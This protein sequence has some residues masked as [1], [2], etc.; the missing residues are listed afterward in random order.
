MLKIGYSGTTWASDFLSHRHPI[1]IHG[2]VCA[3]W[4]DPCNPLWKIQISCITSMSGND[5]NYNTVKPLI[6]SAPNPKTSVFLVSACICL[7]AI[8]CS[9][10][11]SREGRCSWSS[12]DRRCF[13]YIW[14]INNS[15][16]YLSAPYIIDLTVNHLCFLFRKFLNNVG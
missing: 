3:G 9:Q 7:C 14:V 12:A 8:Y 5:R 4:Q 1:S 10:V 15:I 13:N 11:L 2:I 16:A 6:K